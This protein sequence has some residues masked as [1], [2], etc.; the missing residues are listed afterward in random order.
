MDQTEDERM[1]E[2]IICALAVQDGGEIRLPIREMM[3]GGNLYRL[4]LYPDD[5]RES[6]VLVADKMTRISRRRAG[7]RR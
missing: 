5:K 4:R 3:A 6:I 7:R 1:Y 2:A